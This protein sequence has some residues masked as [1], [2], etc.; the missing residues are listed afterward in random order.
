MSIQGFVWFLRAMGHRVRRVDGTWWYN[1]YPHIYINFPFHRPVDPRLVSLWRVFGLDGVAARF[2]CSPAIGRPS[3][4]LVCRH[5][6]YDLSM[7]AQKARNQTR[8]GLDNC[9]VRPVAFDDLHVSGLKL[10]RETLERQGRAIPANF[11]SYWRKYYHFAGK[12]EGAEAWGSFVEESLAAYLI[13][14]EI[15]G[16]LNIFIMRSSREHLKFYPNNALLFS[17]IK[18]TLRRANIQ[19]VSIGLESL[20]QGMEGLDHFK[21]GMG[22][23]RIPIGQRIEI[24]P[25]LKL[26]LRGSILRWLSTYFESKADREEYGKLEGM[27]NWYREQPTIS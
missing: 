26:L 24:S 5:V 6:E 3:F 17:F 15:E 16:C 18:E 4:R 2:C 11:N 23:E 12:A 13:A 1:V 8:R 10:N 20:Q 19:E 9:D 14:F 21:I 7:L 27:L 25:P 22:F